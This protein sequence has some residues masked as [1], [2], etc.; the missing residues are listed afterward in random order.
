MNLNA[1]QTIAATHL[2]GP[3]MVLAGPGSGKTSVIV[4]RTEYLINEGKVPPS[5]IL[6]VTFSRA[7]AREMRE[8][9]IEKTG[10]KQTEVTFG[11][12][13]GV[14]YAILK[15]AYRLGPENILSEKE[16]YELLQPIIMNRSP[17]QASEHDFAEEIAREISD[18]KGNNMDIGNYYS[19]SCPDEIFR[20]IFSDY[21]SAMNARRKLDFD[22]MIL[23]CYE[24]FKKREDILKAWQRKFTYILVDEFQDI[25]RLQYEV[26][27]MLALPE[28]NLFVVGDDDQSIYRFR[29]ARPDIMLNFTKDYKDAARVLLDVNYRCTGNVLE[30]ASKMIRCN[31]S[32]YR[33]KLRTRKDE[34]EDVRCLTFENPPEEY[35]FLVDSIRQHI[36]EGYGYSDIA[37]LFRTNQ[38]AELLVQK[39][40]QFQIPFVMK[41]QLQSL[42]RH[43]IFKDIEAYMR[44]AA[45]EKDRK[46]LIRIMNRPNRYI[47]REAVSGKDVSLR[48]LFAVYADRDWMQDRLVTLQN[49]L[50]IIKNLNPFA[51]VN[52]IAGAVGYEEFLNDYA[53]YRKINP[54]EL[55]D[56]LYRI[57][58]SAK[59]YNTLEEWE[60]YISEYE[61]HLEE[62]QRTQETVPDGVCISTLHRVKGLEYPVVY[63]MNVNEGTIPYRKA[64]LPEALEEERRLLYVGMTRASEKLTLCCVRQEHDKKK[65]P[66]R[67]LSEAGFQI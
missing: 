19:R 53:A 41:E 10:R 37:V 63:I 16:K 27:K 40:S 62:Q 66:S 57:R 48:S 14:F 36:K 20:E 1:S 12:F 58:E 60:K 39:L 29:G 17:D 21:R 6:V 24:L 11:T 42:F 51:A 50:R 26:V 18:V 49:H 33:K 25:N 9:F 30:R 31:G 59:G 23:F 22:D 38:E 45:G 28:N 56:I 4:N 52:F 5:H 7:A 2:S 8:R 13:H 35:G 67:F 55:T 65:D 46:Y 54:E 34:G 44:L 47:S 3:M 61:K 64:V 15:Q 43:W 32:R